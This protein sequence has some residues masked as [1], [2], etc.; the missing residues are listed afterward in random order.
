[1]KPLPSRRYHR[2]DAPYFRGARTTLEG[3]RRRLTEIR[4]RGR[5]LHGVDDETNG[6]AIK[7]IGTRGWVR[8][9]RARLLAADSVPGTS[10]RPK[11]CLWGFPMLIQIARASVIVRGNA[12][13]TMSNRRA[14]TPYARWCG[15]GRRPTAA[16]MPIK[17]RFHLQSIWPIRNSGHLTEAGL[18]RPWPPVSLRF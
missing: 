17:W 15:R 18:Y 6:V 5:M 14:R 10:R 1:M 7:D 8:D 4:R 3:I 11:L 12:D 13:L 16:P 9:W 2:R